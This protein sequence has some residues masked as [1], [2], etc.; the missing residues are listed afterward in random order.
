MNYWFTIQ[1]RQIQNLVA[2]IDS[3]TGIDACTQHHELQA[4]KACKLLV[5][6]CD[7]EQKADFKDI[8]HDVEIGSLLTFLKVIHPEMEQKMFHV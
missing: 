6:C 4:K 5:H 3:W 8:I 2:S 1:Q 7:T